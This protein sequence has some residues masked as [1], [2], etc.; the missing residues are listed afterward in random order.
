MKT[1][2][3]V[4]LMNA[5][6]EGIKEAELKIKEAELKIKEAELKIKEAIEETKI[7]DAVS[8]LERKFSLE[9]VIDILGLSDD[10]L[11][12]I[13]AKMTQITQ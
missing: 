5:R 6:K 9:D 11:Q 3:D 7:A 10:L 13:E 1:T 8:L 2:L 4:A 12:K